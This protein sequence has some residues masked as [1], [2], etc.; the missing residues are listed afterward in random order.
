MSYT[1]G[2]YF[3]VFW[4]NEN[5]YSDVPESKVVGA[6]DLNSKTITVKERGKI[7]TGNLVTTG[8]KQDVQDKLNSIIADSEEQSNVTPTLAV[9]DTL[10]G[11]AKSG[12]V[13]TK[14][15]STITGCIACYCCCMY[16]ILDIQPG[17]IVHNFCDPIC[18]DFSVKE[19]KAGCRDYGNKYRKH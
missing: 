13:T 12:P 3:L 1:V 14:K 19:E 9:S 6:P 15:K 11:A 10:S 5:C 7:Y 18:S 4:P 16:I 8:T 2:R 17:M